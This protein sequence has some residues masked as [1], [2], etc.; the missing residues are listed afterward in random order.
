M[1][2]NSLTFV[3]FFAAVLLGYRLLPG[4]GTRKSW[5]LAASYVFY[6]AW[7]PPFALLLLGSTLVDWWVGLRLGREA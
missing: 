4:W 6:A 5:L 3:A 1:L 2:F 7:N